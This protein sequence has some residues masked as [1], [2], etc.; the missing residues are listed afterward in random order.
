LPRGDSQ[1]RLDA[2]RV[3][4]ELRGKAISGHA[5]PAKLSRLLRDRFVE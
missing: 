5:K 3:G 2:G 1:R 4:R